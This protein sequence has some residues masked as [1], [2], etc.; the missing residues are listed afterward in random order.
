[1]CISVKPHDKCRG[2]WI[3]KFTFLVKDRLPKPINLFL[4]FYNPLL[5]WLLHVESAFLKNIVVLFKTFLMISKINLQLKEKF[6]T[7]TTLFY[8]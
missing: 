8:I 5:P 4:L 2:S 7:K 3:S 6:L 1:M